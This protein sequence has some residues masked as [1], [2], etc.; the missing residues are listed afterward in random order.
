MVPSD[1]IPSF[2]RH[3]HARY[4]TRHPESP[5]ALPASSPIAGFPGY[6]I[7][8]DRRAA[9]SSE[10]GCLLATTFRSPATISACTDSVTGSTFPACCF[11][12]ESNGLPPGPS[13]APRPNPGLPRYW[14][15]QRFD[16]LRIYR[17]ILQTALPA[18]T[19]LQDCYLPQDRRFHWSRRL[20]AH[21]PGPARFPLAPRNLF[22]C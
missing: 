14:P 5:N 3:R 2:A 8:A 9:N 10:R 17:Q 11:A 4:R 13:S 16:P 18:S 21:L 20:P 19:P 12:F 6:R 1:L 15:L 22:Y 7:N